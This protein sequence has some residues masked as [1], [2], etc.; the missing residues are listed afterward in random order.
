[1]E[2]AWL[3][4][5]HWFLACFPSSWPCPFASRWRRPWVEHRHLQKDCLSWVFKF[6]MFCLISVISFSCL[7][8][9][10]GSCGNTSTLVIDGYPSCSIFAPIIVIVPLAALPL[11]ITAFLPWCLCELIFESD[12]TNW[13][14]FFSRWINFSKLAAKRK[15]AT[16]KLIMEYRPIVYM[17]PEASLII[18]EYRPIIYMALRS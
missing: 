4:T 2:K 5:Y 18:M 16:Q 7:A 11:R 12:G 3:A 8:I 10:K 9:G 13:N 15:G 17:P 1:M 14:R 6:A